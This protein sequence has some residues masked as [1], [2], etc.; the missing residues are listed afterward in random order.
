[1][2]NCKAYDIIQ[3]ALYFF[4][5]AVLSEI[6]KVLILAAFYVSRLWKN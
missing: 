2:Y 5:Y 4:L 6:I 1:M 3:D